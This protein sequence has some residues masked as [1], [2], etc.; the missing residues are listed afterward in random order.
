VGKQKS[1]MKRIERTPRESRQTYSKLCSFEDEALK[2][3][4]GT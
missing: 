4:M 3:A 2:D 1:D